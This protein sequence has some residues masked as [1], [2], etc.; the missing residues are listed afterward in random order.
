VYKFICKISLQKFW[1]HTT[2]QLNIF[3]DRAPC[4]IPHPP[5][6]SLAHIR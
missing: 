5:T 6:M 2:V 3:A 4:S 1:L